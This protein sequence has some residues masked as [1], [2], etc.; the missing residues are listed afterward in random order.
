MTLVDAQLG[1]I[2][3]D[4]GQNYST[5]WS[6]N[7]PTNG[8][9]T[10]QQAAPQQAAAAPQ[11]APVDPYAQ[12][13]GQANY[14]ALRNQYA[15]QKS[16]I[17]STSLDAANQGA[18]KLNRSILDF[19]DS[20]RLGQ[21][22]INN[23]AVQ[24]DLARRQGQSGVQGMVS[25]GLRSGAT[26]LANKNATNSSATEAI[27]KAYG[28]LGRRE[29]GKV[30]NQYALGQNAVQQAQDEFGVQ[31]A[32][33]VRGIQGSKNDILNGI[34]SEARNQLA[35]L[36]SQIAGASLPDRINIEAEKEAIRQQALGR[37]QQ[38]DAQLNEGL[39]GIK[40]S[41]PE[42]RRTKALELQNLGQVADNSFDYTTQ[43][44]AQFQGTGQFASNLPLFTFPRS[45]RAA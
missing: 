11:Q 24:N 30:G 22:K 32:S 2:A 3:Q 10:P 37:L 25:R 6:P 43:A 7:G 8:M 36:D 4:L 41:T 5:P 15:T 9:F 17:Y 19:L 34:V 45:R 42:E 29:M 16:N 39:A 28:D 20:N 18:D 21:S 1:A 44:P 33:G 26:M 23:Q 27:A 13:G 31:Q 35:S 12:W 38:Y 14:D 40:A